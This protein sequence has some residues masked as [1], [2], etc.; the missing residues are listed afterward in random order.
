MLQKNLLSVF[1]LLGTVSAYLWGWGE[2]QLDKDLEQKQTE[3]WKKLKGDPDVVELPS[4]LMYKVLETGSGAVTPA[5][6]Q[7]CSC[8]YEGELANGKVFD[9]SYKR[10]QPLDLAPDQV[11]KGWTEAMTRMKEGDKWKLYIPS[12][13][14]YGSSGA[15]R[16]IPGG[17][18]LIFTMEMVKI[19]GNHEM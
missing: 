13:L 15:G 1:L 6:S 2:A 19:H 12:E 16:D 8:H 18:N 10:G 17:A 4:G 11:I 3:L 5:K 9:S 14:G 7:I